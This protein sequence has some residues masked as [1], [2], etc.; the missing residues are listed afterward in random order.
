MHTQR[1]VEHPEQYY[2]LLGMVRGQ[3]VVDGPYRSE[4]EAKTVAR[5][6]MDEGRWRVI[7]LRSRDPQRVK[8][9]L[10]HQLVTEDGK[11]LSNAMEDMHSRPT[12]LRSVD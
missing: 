1:E 7:P 10:R 6:K 11:S 5:D 9:I 3:R 4:A 2:W 12:N 8:S